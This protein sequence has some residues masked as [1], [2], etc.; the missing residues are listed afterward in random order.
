[1]QMASTRISIALLAVASLLAGQNAFTQ[2]LA[3][4]PGKTSAS[5]SPKQY[6]ARAFFTTT[7]YGLA[8]GFAW[9]PDDQKLLI[10][11]D[12]TGIF[13]AYALPVAGA[14]KSALTTSTTDSTFPVSW[15][16]GDARVLVTA[17]QGGNE[18]SHLYVREVSGEIRD[19]T[20]AKNGKAS[21]AGWSADDQ[22]FYVLTNEREPKSFDLYRYAAKDYARTRVFQNDAVWEIGAI[23]PDGRYVALV[24]PKTSADSDIYLLDTKDAKQSPQLITKH[25]G[26]VTHDA[27]EF[28]HNSKQL[29][30]AT[31]EHGEFTQAWTYDVASGRKAPLIKADWDVSFVTFSRSGNFRVW[32]VNEDARTA[33]HILDIRTGKQVT[34]P[35]LP[36]GDIAQVRFSRDEN[37]L[38][39]MLSS[40]TS[41]SD[42][43][44]RRAGGVR[45][46][47]G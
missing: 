44:E 21:F 31:D 32:G 33:V 37:R 10:G 24:K 8:S 38:A 1:M 2:Q 25:D 19:L 47:P 46:V 30:Y 13:N 36:Q 14:G 27:Y 23:S 29:V 26:N 43:R 5:T 9:S 4:T 6:D 39:L 18:I 42:P 16:P 20:P 40:D 15:F 45:G 41:P 11:S 35:D 22:Y 7:A 3:T 12:E 34:L 28:T 17:D